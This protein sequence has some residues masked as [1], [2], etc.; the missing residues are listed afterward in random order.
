MWNKTIE[1]VGHGFIVTASSTVLCSN[2]NTVCSL[3]DNLENWIESATGL[4]GKYLLE[5]WCHIKILHFVM[6]YNTWQII[7][8]INCMTLK[9]AVFIFFLLLLFNLKSFLCC[10]RQ[11]YI[12]SDFTN[13]KLF[14]IYL[15]LYLALRC[16]DKYPKNAEE[17]TLNK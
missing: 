1:Q 2:V 16:L 12:D 9:V 10:F 14:L 3:V 6:K 4:S 15:L 17:T 13:T 11:L 8:I 7:K 5:Y